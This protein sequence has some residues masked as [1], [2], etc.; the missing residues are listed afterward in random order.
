MV[1]YSTRENTF[2]K[3][4]FSRKVIVE[5]EICEATFKGRKNIVLLDYGRIYIQPH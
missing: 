1:K 4:A 3:D 5:H 2:Y